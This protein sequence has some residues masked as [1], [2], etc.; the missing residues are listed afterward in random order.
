MPA[1]FRVLDLVSG[2]RA[3]LAAVRESYFEHLRFA[4]TVGAMLAAAGIAC[5]LHALVPA[6]CTGTASR[7]I[8]QLNAL[9][10]DR[11]LLAD[12]AREAG[13]AI[14]F[15]FLFAL[16][17]SAAVTLWVAGA[18]AVLALPLSLIAFALP[19]ALLVSNPELAADAADA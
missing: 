1:G 13:A 10:A 5:M 14:G 6:L 17:L 9:L 18:S 4:S 15:T 8:R 7:T 2:S 12:A 3:H 16:S 19:L 11:Q